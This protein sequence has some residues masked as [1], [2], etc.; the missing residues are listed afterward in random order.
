M[1]IK[2]LDP[3]LRGDDELIGGSLAGYEWPGHSGKTGLPAR[4]SKHWR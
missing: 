1:K 3:R 2:M 4:S